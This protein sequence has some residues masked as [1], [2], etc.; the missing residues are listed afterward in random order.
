M[1]RD[2]PDTYA[3][4]P[5]PRL[6]TRAD[7]HSRGV[8]DTTIRS[9]R[10]NGR[11]AL[12]AP[13]VYL[14]QP[15][16]CRQDEVRA[17]V[18][19]GGPHAAVSG[20]EGVRLWG[21]RPRRTVSRIL[22]LVPRDYGRRDTELI[23]WRRTDRLPRPV[24]VG[25]VQVAPAARAVADHALELHWLDD[26]RAVVCEAVQR[27]LARP[28]E[29]QAEYEAGP[30][31][32]SRHLRVAIEDLLDDAASAPEARAGRALR[33]ARVGSFRQNVDLIVRGR[34][35]VVDVLFEDVSAVLEID[36][37][38]FHFSEHDWQRTLQ[39]DQLLQS[40]GYA[41]LHVTPKQLLDERS[42]VALVRN[43]LESLRQM[44]RA[45]P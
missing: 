9:R 27:G 22:V 34:R 23:R 29:I 13:D 32:R 35:V 8:P 20:A 2:R 16:R 28:E 36:S 33:N 5:L 44:R 24:V 41:V 21:I 14:T 42:F 6:L 10:R 37:R 43:W 7:A 4:R 39:R 40:A 31:N 18:M 26:V 45:A 15:G 38:E 1:Q 25:G 12:L 11:W 30:R 17:S 19:A 3:N